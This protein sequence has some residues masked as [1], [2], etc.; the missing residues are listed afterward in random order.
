MGN[1]DEKELDPQSS[2]ERLLTNPGASAKSGN[3]T[4]FTI[5]R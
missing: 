2:L 3:S 4:I 1:A 5:S